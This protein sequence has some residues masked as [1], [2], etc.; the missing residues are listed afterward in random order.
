MTRHA[1]DDPF[2]RPDSAGSERDTPLDT[3]ELLVLDV[4]AA[5]E[6]DRL[7]TAEFGLPS[8]VLME[9]ASRELA[10]VVFD[11]FAEL[12]EAQRHAGVLIVCGPGNNGGDGLALLR[13]LDNANVCAIA[14]CIGAPRAHSDAAAQHAV[15]TKAALSCL[16][17]PDGDLSAAIRR[18][19]PTG[20]I[21]SIIVDCLIGTGLTR[22]PD[23][24]IA[25][26]IASINEL[27][28]KGSVVIAADIPSGLDAQAGTTPGVAIRADITVT[29][30]ALKPGLLTLEAQSCVGEIVIADIGVPRTLVERLARRICIQQHSDS[31]ST[32]PCQD[33]PRRPR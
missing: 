23:A 8:L 4:A 14:V 18:L 1:S 32:R 20:G 11:T 12:P 26:A 25:R 2:S 22:S 9:N 17:A 6:L 30:A 21:P 33:P 31:E 5:R 19:C 13:H 15:C 7:A 28:A 10:E 3:S 29:F 24:T 27:G 16:D